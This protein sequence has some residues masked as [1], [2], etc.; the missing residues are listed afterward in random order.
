MTDKIGKYLAEFLEYRNSFSNPKKAYD[1]YIEGRVRGEREIKELISQIE[2]SQRREV[3]LKKA[4]EFYADE[5]N[6]SLDDYYGISGQMRSRVVMY[7]DS[8]ERND[9]YQYAGCRARQ[10]LKEVEEIV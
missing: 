8:E 1:Y 7:K 10:A 9:C 2:L 4:V 5:M 6:W 3:A